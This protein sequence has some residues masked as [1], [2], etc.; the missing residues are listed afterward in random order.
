MEEKKGFKTQKTPTH[1]EVKH[2]FE[3]KPKKKRFTFFFTANLRNGNVAGFF[4][5]G[6]AY[7][8]SKKKNLALCVPRVRDT[9]WK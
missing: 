5:G 1:E 8:R 4:K 9:A 2:I 6:T 3:S 7:K